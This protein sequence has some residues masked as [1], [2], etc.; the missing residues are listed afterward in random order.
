[1]VGI[2]RMIYDL[3]KFHL[4]GLGLGKTINI[5]MMV[6][7][8]NQIVGYYRYI[9]SI[10]HCIRG[11]LCYNS[12]FNSESIGSRSFLLSDLNL[13]SGDV[14]FYSISNLILHKLTSSTSLN[15]FSFHPNISTLQYLNVILGSTLSSTTTIVSLSKFQPWLRLKSLIINNLVN[16]SSCFIFNPKSQ[17]RKRSLIYIL[18]FYNLMGSNLPL[19]IATNLGSSLEKISIITI[20]RFNLSST[21]MTSIILLSPCSCITL[22]NNNI[23]ILSNN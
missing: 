6:V 22:T 15:K 21:T 19:V 7:M 20:S 18:N 8:F 12:V 1:M 17:T 3:S 23:P 13:C 5:N 11:K 10:R 16:N 14:G 9:K 2:S 4:L